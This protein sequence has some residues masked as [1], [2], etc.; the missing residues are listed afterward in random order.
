MDYCDISNLKMSSNILSSLFYG[1]DSSVFFNPQSLDVSGVSSLSAILAFTKF[2]N[3]LGAWYIGNVTTMANFAQGV[4]TW[5]QSNYEASWVGW[6]GWSGGVPNIT[7]NNNVP[8][9]GGS[10]TVSIGSDGAAARSYAINT[11]GWIVTDGGEI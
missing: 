7:L 10:A 11:L 9:H 2:D 5:S 1:I 8:M 6:L 3:D 4:T